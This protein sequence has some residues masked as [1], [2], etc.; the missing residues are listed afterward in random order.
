[1][2]RNTPH[3]QGQWVRAVP[4]D[5]TPQNVNWQAFLNGRPDR[6]FDPFR[7]INWRLFWEFSGGNITENAVHQI[8]W[9]MSALD[10]PVPNAAY[11]A[12][13]IFSEKD[14][15]E[16]PDTIVVTYEFPSDIVVTW[17]STFSNGHYG[18]GERLVGGTDLVLPGGGQPATRHAAEE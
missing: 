15:R 9:I 3:G 5:C 7:F 17:Q 11:M 6:G 18:L 14:K 2:S 16:V 12:G 13:G 4:S 1:M 8:A 10:L